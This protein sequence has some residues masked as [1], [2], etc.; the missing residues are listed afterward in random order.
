MKRVTRRQILGPVGL[1][2]GSCVLSSCFNKNVAPSSGKGKKAVFPWPYAELDPD[3]TAKRTY[4]DCEKGKC[5][6]GVFAP[7]MSR[8]AEEH[9]DPYRSF[10]VGMMRYGVGGAGGSGSLCGALNGGAALIGLFAKSEDDMKGLIRGLFLWYEQAELPAYVPEKPI[11]DVE[12]PRSVSGSVLC[13][14]SLT[15]WCETS[16]SKAFSKP[17]EERC[18]RL[19]ADTAKKTVEILNA[20]FTGESLSVAELSEDVR[21]CRSC[22]AKGSEISNSSGYMNCGSCHSSL[23]KDHP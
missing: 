17:R 2:A 20:Y 19:A 13:H 16:G 11:L 10:P 22:H 4:Y 15:R 1:A 8:L 18:K 21:R 3:V 6:Y 7:V 12:V 14:V 9:G 5:M 23:A